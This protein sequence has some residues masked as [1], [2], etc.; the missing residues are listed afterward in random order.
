M[1]FVKLTLALS[2]DTPYH[3]NRYTLR[4][5]DINTT[6]NDED[7]GSIH[8]GLKFLCSAAAIGVYFSKRS[9]FVPSVIF[10]GRRVPKSG[11]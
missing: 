10:S 5:Y 3:L 4:N 2:Y 7:E 9:F 6:N 11:R 1:I 8:A